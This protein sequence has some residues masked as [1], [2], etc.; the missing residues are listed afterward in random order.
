[1]RD[2]DS[3]MI[4]HFIIFREKSPHIAYAESYHQVMGDSTTI[5]DGSVN[6]SVHIF[7]ETIPRTDSLHNPTSEH[8]AAMPK[9]QLVLV[10]KDPD[11]TD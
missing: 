11:L 4:T 2:T 9:R 6:I 10:V 8:L 1:M 7:S 5:H 3:H